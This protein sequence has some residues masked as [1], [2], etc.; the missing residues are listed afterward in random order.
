MINARSL[1]Y[2]NKKTFKMLHTSSSDRPLGVQ[3]LGKDPYFI[4]RSLEK[5]REYEFDI[6]DF[7]AA[8]PIKKVTNK[9]KGASLLKNPKELNYLLKFIVKNSKVPVT[10]KMRL[11][12]DS[13][14]QARDIALYAEDAGIKA[15]FL[16]GRTKVQGY[17]GTVDYESIGK[18]KKALSIPL[19]ASGD[20]LTPQLAKRMFDETG[21]D[22][23]AVAR[24]ALGNPWIFNGIKEFL[25]SG[26]TPTPPDIT[27]IINTMKEHF[28]LYVD[29][30]GEKR[31]V[32]N[33]RK[34]YIWYTHG[35]HG[36]RPL[37]S[38]VSRARTKEEIVHLIE[39][40]KNI[41]GR[42]S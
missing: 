18:V 17:S 10:V 32:R 3:L 37:R 15:V 29:Y 28:D 7:N 20:I 8:C 26:K 41:P 24:G 23:V 16:H 36:I 13:H 42:I 4:V 35:F 25:K 11:G 33:F 31:G 5:L 14:S 6:L 21:C 9:G 34:F 38:G 19:I 2:S 40:L 22:Y 39:D 27:S 12:W 1:S 30:F